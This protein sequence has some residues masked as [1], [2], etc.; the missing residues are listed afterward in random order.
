MP[1]PL[2]RPPGVPLIKKRASD[3]S[4]KRPPT[5]PVPG[6]KSPGL[7]K[8]P[9]QTTNK[10]EKRERAKRLPKAPQTVDVFYRLYSPPANGTADG[11][12]QQNDDNE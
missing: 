10:S 9:T 3:L 11:Q 4:T 7:K 1:D 6:V 5:Q 8:T 2:S 12:Q